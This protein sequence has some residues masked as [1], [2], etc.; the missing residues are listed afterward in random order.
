MRRLW[1]RGKKM[2]FSKAKKNL[3]R[4]GFEV[5]VFKTGREAKAYLNGELDGTSIGFGGSKTLDQL[6]L[7]ESLSEHNDVYWHWR[8]DPDYA[9]EKSMT[10]EV[11]MCSANGLAETG[12]IVFV[13]GNGNRAA[14][15][16]WGHKRLILVV[17]S[18]KLAPDYTMAVARC[19]NV[20]CTMRNADFPGRPAC[21]AAGTVGKRCFDCKSKDR[22]CKAMVTLWQPMNGT[23]C[24]VILIDEELGY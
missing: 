22:E 17:G 9:R 5:H 13:D 18:N 10:T 23:P 7:F 4:N 11:Y 8:Q 3:E 6:G 24:E 20:A 14:S 21:V 19:R 16:L 12:E 1:M 2:D 15:I